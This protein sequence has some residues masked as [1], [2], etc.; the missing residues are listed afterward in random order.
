MKQTESS[1]LTPIFYVYY[2]AFS[3]DT[4]GS[5]KFS[6]P[7]QLSANEEEAHGEDSI[8]R[9]DGRRRSSG[10]G[11]LFSVLEENREKMG[12]P[13]YSVQAMTMDEVFLNAV[14]E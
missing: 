4:F 9:V 5:I 8:T 11:A 7:A 14:R 13:F 3:Q 1:L 12:L 6:V 10:V 2:C